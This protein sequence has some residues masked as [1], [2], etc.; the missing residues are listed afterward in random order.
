M[1]ELDLMSCITGKTSD[2][3]TL[4]ISGG[5]QMLKR[6]CWFQSNKEEE[7]GEEA[8]LTLPKAAFCTRVW[9]LLCWQLY[10]ILGC[11][12]SATSLLKSSGIMPLPSARHILSFRHSSTSFCTLDDINTISVCVSGL[13]LPHLITIFPHLRPYTRSRKLIF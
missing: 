13:V 12:A 11:A 7:E 8:H 3:E 4:L 10:S 6:Q 1:S 2:V 5:S 9:R